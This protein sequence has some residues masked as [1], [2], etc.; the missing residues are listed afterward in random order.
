MDCQE[1][2]RKTLLEPFFLKKDEAARVKSFK[3]SVP[4][5][6]EALQTHFTEVKKTMGFNQLL[7]HREHYLPKGPSTS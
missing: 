3:D 6:E 5:I 4:Y 2:F 7:E 1:A